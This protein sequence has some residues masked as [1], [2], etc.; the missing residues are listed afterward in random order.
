MEEKQQYLTVEQVA[1]MLQID[2]ESVRRYVRQGKLPAIKLGKK[3]IRIDKKDLEI[4]LA[5]LKA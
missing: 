2:P 5:T 4:F 3:Y 1:T